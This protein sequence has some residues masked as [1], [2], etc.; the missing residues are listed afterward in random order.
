MKVIIAGGRNLYVKH[1]DITQAIV[2]SG[3][4]VTEIVSGGATGVDECGEGYALFDDIPLTRFPAKWT[5]YGKTAGP[6]RNKG[7]AEYAD[8][9]IAFPGGKGTANIVE[10][11]RKLGKPVYKVTKPIET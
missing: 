1:A 6:T 9:L 2:N 7:M 11:M 4:D 5:I 10:Q 8:A 3:F